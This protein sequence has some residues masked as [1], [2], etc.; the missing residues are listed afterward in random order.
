MK[1][2]YPILLHSYYT[3]LLHSRATS[4]VCALALTFILYLI[5]F[6]GFLHLSLPCEKVRSRNCDW[7]HW[8]SKYWR[9]WDTDDIENLPLCWS[10]Q[11]E[12]PY[13]YHYC[14]ILSSL[15]YSKVLDSPRLLCR[16]EV[17][18]F[19]Y[20]ILWNFFSYFVLTALVLIKICY[21]VTMF[22]C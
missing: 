9:T 21:F 13:Y 1:L 8:S 4:V 11:H 7:S 16:H 10:C 14:L 20:H 2:I 18:Y 17:C 5:G 19:V 22:I 15:S 3:I 12:Y 6:L